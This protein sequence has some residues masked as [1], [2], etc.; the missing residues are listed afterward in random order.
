M[1]SP[2][3]TPEDIA[4]LESGLAQRQQQVDTQWQLVRRLMAAAFDS[5]RDP[6]SQPYQSGV[7]D[8][9]AYKLCGT[10]LRNPYDMGTAAA[11]AWLAGCDE[12]V[13]ILKQRNRTGVPA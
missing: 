9:L 5:A 11:D 4:A 12:G 1:N 3:F 10:H 6:R 7:R 13:A 8:T 2:R